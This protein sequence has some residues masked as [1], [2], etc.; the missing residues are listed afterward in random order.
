MLR[1]FYTS[2]TMGLTKV[3]TLL[4]TILLHLTHATRN[5]KLFI[6]SHC[7]SEFCVLFHF[8]DTT[9]RSL[10]IK[11]LHQ[12]SFCKTKPILKK[13]TN[14]TFVISLN[15]NITFHFVLNK[16]DFSGQHFLSINMYIWDVSRIWE[17][18]EY[19]SVT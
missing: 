17:G 8:H 15:S 13:V 18:F 9:E 16:E 1:T 14:L 6:S 7:K 3:A 11:N 2:D 12:I 5:A 4:S 10:K 19:A